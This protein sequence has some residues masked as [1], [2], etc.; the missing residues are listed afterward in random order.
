MKSS[1]LS[2][3]AA[4]IVLLFTNLSFRTSPTE[5]SF[6]EVYFSNKLDISDLAKM[7]SDL[8]KKDI[9]LNYDYLKFNKDGK[10]K[11][12]EYHV[13]YKKI[14]GSDETTDTNTEIGFIINT[15]PSPKS[16][17][18][19]IVGKKEDIQK[20]HMVLDSQK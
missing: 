20:R 17:Y 7:Q 9:K 12:I 1:K 2:M 6:V 8:S 10:L 5:D 19:I 11:G 14:G 16:K 15:D 13:S 3:A 18:G 4:I